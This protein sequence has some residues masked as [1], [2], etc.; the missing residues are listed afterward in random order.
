[1][2]VSAAGIKLLEYH[3]VWVGGDVYTDPRGH[4]TIGYG[5]K[6]EPGEHWGHITHA[7]GVALLAK[8]AAAAA[9]VVNSTIKV[10]LNQA[11]F[12][13]LVDFEFPVGPGRFPN[14][15]LV[16]DIN[17][18]NFNMVGRDMMQWTDHGAGYAIRRDQDDITLF[19]TGVYTYR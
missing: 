18:G 15:D 10:R 12:D 13:A 4:Q 1:M 14:T 8:D 2:Q 11:Q 17:A 16:H 9:A 6:V 7:Q 19:N 3:E 5:H